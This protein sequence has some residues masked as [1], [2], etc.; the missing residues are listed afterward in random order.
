MP[1]SG[2]EFLTGLQ[3]KEFSLGRFQA[4]KRRRRASAVKGAKPNDFTIPAVTAIPSGNTAPTPVKPK[5]AA[6]ELTMASAPT[7]PLT[8][9][10]VL[11]LDD[12]IGLVVIEFH[13]DRGVI[14]NSIP[15]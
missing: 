6:V 8:I 9:N 12:G 14:T 3:L 10:P 15:S 2:K 13:N 5:A 7:L 4:P 1:G 11:R